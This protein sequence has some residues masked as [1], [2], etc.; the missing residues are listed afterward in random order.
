VAHNSALADF[1]RLP[2]S[3]FVRLPTVSN[4]FACHP[5]TVWRRVKGG[6]L[7]RPVKL[8]PQST[9]WR[10]G[11]LRAALAALAEAAYG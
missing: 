4:L 9:A 1:D 11:D 6:T 2:D 3:A 7:P 8:G 5:C 10:V